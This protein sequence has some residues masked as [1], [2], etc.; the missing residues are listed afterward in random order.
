MSADFD[1]TDYLPYLLNRAGSRIANTFTE[2]IRDRGITLQMWR[3][4][5]AL[6]HDNGLRIGALA[7]ATSI[8]VSTL[9]R[10]VGAMQ[11]KQLVDRRR[12]DTGDARVVTVSLTQEG[13]TIT[14]ALVPLA[15][16]YEA[17]ALTGFTEAE[18][19]QLK[20]MLRRL[21]TNMADLDVPEKDAA[22]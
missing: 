11:K 20:A 17:T 18:A 16:N 6:H 22:A 12:P 10:L 21:Y 4:L 19:R 5:A 14:Q 3:V 7:E 8:D 2:A 9:S 1:I 13:R 15:L